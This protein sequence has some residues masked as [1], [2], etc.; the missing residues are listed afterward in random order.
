[1]TAPASTRAPDR[2]EITGQFYPVEYR[3]GGR[4]YQ[5]WLYATDET[6]AARVC[7]ERGRGEYI[8]TFGRAPTPVRPEERASVCVVATEQGDAFRI[9]G[10]LW[11]GHLGIDSGSCSC[12]DVL[13]D[14]GILHDAVHVFAGIPRVEEGPDEARQRWEDIVRRVRTLECIVPGYL[15]PSERAETLRAL[16]L[17]HAQAV[18]TFHP[19]RDHVPVGMGD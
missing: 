12:E 3:Q 8:D 18:A 15:S 11:I 2:S 13:G 10:I 1:M 6:D 19:M 4:L 17:D 16:G 5:T 14:R 9:H 7:A